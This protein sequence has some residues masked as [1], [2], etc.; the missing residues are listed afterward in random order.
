[1]MIVR[2]RNHNLVQSRQVQIQLKVSSKIFSL[3]S[4][5]TVFLDRILTGNKPEA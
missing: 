4:Y 3:I 2:N 1:M 5:F